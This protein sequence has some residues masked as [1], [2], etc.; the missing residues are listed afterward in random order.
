MITASPVVLACGAD[1]AFAMPMAVTLFSAISHLTRPAE[2]YVIDGGLGGRTRDRLQE[3]LGQARGDTRVTF[4]N[5]PL[6][7]L[8]R[9]TLPLGGHSP[10]AYLRLLLPA[11]LPPEV[12]HILYLD[13]DLLVRS[14]LA[15]LWDQRQMVDAIAGVPDYASPVVSGRGGVPN[16]R[17][18]GLPANAPYV[19]SGVL[20]MNLTAWRANDLAGQII[21]YSL[22]HQAV[23]RFADQDGINALLCKRCKL[24]DMRWNIPV[25]LGFDAVLR[26]VEPNPVLTAAVARRAELLRAGGIIHFLGPRKPWQYGLGARNQWEW[27]QWLSRSGWFDDDTW[28]Y[29]RLVL[30]LRCDA[31]LRAGVRAVRR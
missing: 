7:V 15:Q 13:S 16:W 20:M 8:R 29:W 30:A 24:L 22:A 17:E 3:V 26:G 14:D 4:L 1:E 27:L 10:M 2:I 19:N 21:D 18:R 5:P 12:T 31:L 6:D 9:G 11:A 25:Y 23:N 28:R